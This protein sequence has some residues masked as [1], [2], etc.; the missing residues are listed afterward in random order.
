[1][2]G[3]EAMNR[4]EDFLQSPELNEEVEE[5]QDNQSLDDEAVA[6]NQ[7]T[8]ESELPPE[9]NQEIKEQS[10]EA[11]L[12]SGSTGK[13]LTWTTL[14][15]VVTK[16]Y[17]VPVAV[18]LGLVFL[19]L[20]IVVL[21]Y[22][23]MGG[24]FDYI[25]PKCTQMHVSL[26]TG[27]NAHV[28]NLPIEHY[29]I[30]H[31]HSATKD[32][33]N[34]NDNLYR[35]LAIALNTEI[36]SSDSCSITFVP[37]VDDIYQFEILS[38]DSEEYQEIQKG[39]KSV[40]DLVMV[41][42]DS[43]KYYRTTL[44][45]FCTNY[46][47]P[48]SREPVEDDFTEFLE[49]EEEPEESP[50]EYTI[51][52]LP[53][54]KF[55]THWVEENV[56]NWNYK[57]C[58][59]N[60]PENAPASCFDYEWNYSDEEE[61]DLIYVD[62]GTGTGI[63]IYAAQYLTTEEN[64]SYEGVLKTF[65]PEKDWE[66]RTNDSSL[67]QK[68][69]NI[70]HQCTGGNVPFH[71]TPLSREAFIDLV[72]NFLN[73]GNYRP[74]AQY[75]IDYAG[76]IY[77][78][79]KLK[80]IN[81][82]LIYIF[83]RKET[84][85]TSNSSDTQ[86]YNYYGMG[87]CNTCSHGTFYSSFMEGVEDLFDYFVNAGSL[88]AVVKK[89]SY[90]GT[91]LANPGDSGMGG[92][93]YLI[94]PEIYGPNYSRCNSSYRCASAKGGAGCVLTTE[95]E[96]QAYIDWQAKKYIDH[97]KAIFKLGAETCSFTDGVYGDTSNTSFLD[98]TIDQFLLENGSSLDEFNDA[99]FQIGC[100][101]K[102]TGAAVGKVAGTAVSQLAEYGKKFHYVWGGYHANATRIYGVP[103]TWGPSGADFS[104]HGPDC[105]GFV[106]WALYN[107]GFT[108]ISRTAN[109]WGRVGVRVPLS[110]QRLQVGDFI[111]TPGSS[112]AYTH[113]VIITN[114]NREEGYYNVVEAQGR[115]TGV[116]FNTVPMTD[117]VRVGVL[118]SDYYAAAA[119]A[120]EFDNLCSSKGY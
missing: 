8:N 99:L 114:V 31:I 73:A 83:A 68:G 15:G 5:D 25:A 117:G 70:K 3:G 41:Q 38:Q 105:S 46:V 58:P 18:I 74:Y 28:V 1:M 21:S 81:P 90:L 79:G 106:S 20:I 43:N 42:K 88:D 66:L 2:F 72:T 80:N 85:F 111:V 60:S 26:G 96:R 50:I 94:L 97:R 33:K 101:Y 91:Y 24:G 112:G 113:I 49:Q 71:T 27:E 53:G 103:A 39:I 82:E 16:P 62:G 119:K 12:E 4:E 76:E 87:H 78:M 34:V 95:E 75:F 9:I 44:D 77:D 11:P 57:N 98:K 6:E 29:I 116:I 102:G 35:V 86:H 89:Y 110:D 67:A 10:E 100:E 64:K 120:P 32:L 108:L 56:E 107:S 22:G 59:C 13:N 69:G 14:K 84:G 51:P 30:S 118:M 54:M 52:Q 63:S 92:C 45:G 19:I 17:F 115:A 65:Y 61:P 109:E 93:Y 48:T 7:E 36:Q 37:E 23:G 104:L 40:K 47:S 55:P